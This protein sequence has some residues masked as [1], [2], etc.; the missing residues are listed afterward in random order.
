[1]CGMEELV[2]KLEPSKSYCLKN[3]TIKEFHGMRNVSL[4]TSQK[5]SVCVCVMLEMLVK[6]GSVVKEY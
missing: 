2:G 4:S 3:V 6:K 5:Y 1:M